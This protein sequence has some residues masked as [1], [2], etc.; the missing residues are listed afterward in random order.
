[1]KLLL[2]QGLPRSTILHLSNAGS[3][4][5]HVGNRGLATA[6]DAEMLELGGMES[7]SWSCW[8]AESTQ[9]WRFRALRSRL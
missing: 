2:D 4:S 6:S 7:V 3:E 9:Y 8:D 5:T 1:M